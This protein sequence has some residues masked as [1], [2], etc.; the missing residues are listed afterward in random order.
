MAIDSVIASVSVWVPLGVDAAAL[1][2]FPTHKGIGGV[3][4]KIEKRSSRSTDP[5][6]RSD[7]V[8]QAITEAARKLDGALKG[9]FRE[10]AI[11]TGVTATLYVT[12]HAG[13][14][15]GFFGVHPSDIATLARLGV[16]VSLDV[17]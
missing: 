12:V 10:W 8:S 17:I 4:F 9:D 1:G 15:S 3:V 5:E 6:E 16:G 11:S 7:A 2:H 13:S 14:Q